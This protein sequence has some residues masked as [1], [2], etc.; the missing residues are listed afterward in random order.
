MG[1]ADPKSRGWKDKISHEMVDYA[2]NVAYLALI[3]AVFTQYRRL[4]LAAHDII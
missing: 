4:L 3:F 2:I 1:S